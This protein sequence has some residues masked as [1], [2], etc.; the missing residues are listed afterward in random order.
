ME[1]GL[2]E[3]AL[4]LSRKPSV[5]VARIELDLDSFTDKRSFTHGFHPYP[6]K[7]VPHIPREIIA[8]LSV[9]GD[10]VLDPFCGSGTSLVEAAL[11]GRPSIGIDLNPIAC[12]AARVKSTALGEDSLSE[13][14]VVADGLRELLFRAQFGRLES[15]E[16]CEIPR[17]P[18]HKIDHWFLPHVQCELALIKR[19]ID[20]CTDSAARDMLLLALSASIVKVSRQDSETRW[21]AVSKNTRP[22]DAVAE[23]IKRLEYMIPRARE[24]SAT[25]RAASRVINQSSSEELPLEPETIRLVVTSPPYPNSFDYYLYHKLRMF[26]LGFDH[27]AVQAKEIGSRNRHSDMSQGLDTYID[28]I[29]PVLTNLRRLLHQ[30]GWCCFVVGDA[31]LKGSFV[32]C[33][34][35]FQRLFEEA[36]MVVQRIIR[37]DQ[38]KYTAGF[39][40]NS[41]ARPKLSHVL[42]ATRR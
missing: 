1:R 23:V 18:N 38:R 22:G 33:G 9:E 6:A 35:L 8:K 14:R 10:L 20:A 41:T 7:F 26:W 3:S 27:Y 32:D 29:R 12:L 24:F 11:L 39:L 13:V 16:R 21:A 4:E 19:E 42:L 28:G 17:I 15:V 34:A 36:G 5:D 31:I 30:D 37:F 40:K 25:C 2:S